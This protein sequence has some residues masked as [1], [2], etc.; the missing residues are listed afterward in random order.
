MIQTT[1]IEIVEVAPRDGFQSINEPIAT[2]IKIQI[3][4]ALIAAGLTRIEFGSFVSPRAIPQMVDMIE[5]AQHFRTDTRA[6]L[7][8]LVPNV[9]GAE[10]ALKNGVQEIVYVFSASE[11]HNLSN[12]GAPISQSIQGLADVCQAISGA[13]IALR[14]DLA[15]AFDCPFDGTVPMDAVLHALEHIAQLAPTS[16]IALCDTTGRANPFEVAERFQKVM[17]MEALSNNTWAFHGHD[18]YG[19][20][21]AN[22]MAANRAGVAVIDTSAGGLGGCPFAP[23]ATGNTA[24]EDLVFAARGSNAGCAV[25]LAALL[26]VADRIAELPGTSMGGHLRTVPRGKLPLL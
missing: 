24:T 2:G 1:P 4:E 9:R 18:T 15:T 26:E 23:G 12:V 6:R 3:I 19:M 20:G 14:V 11:A 22:A 21:I 7:A 8:A 16:E 13:D 17:T 10:L 5:I 25:D